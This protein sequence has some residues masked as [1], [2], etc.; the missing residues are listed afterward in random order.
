MQGMDWGTVEMPKDTGRG[1]KYH[2]RPTK[3]L[4][5]MAEKQQSEAMAISD[6][7]QDDL[8]VWLGKR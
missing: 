7:G 5:F 8:M 2:R 6:G 4:S 1:I 3:Q